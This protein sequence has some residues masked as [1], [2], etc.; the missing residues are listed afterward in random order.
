ME[1]NGALAAS[2]KL[3]SG[4]QFHY[5]LPKRK[6]FFLGVETKHTARAVGARQRESIKKYIF[7]KKLEN[8]RGLVL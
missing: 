5:P 2:A 4:T 8:W 1:S 7:Y 3:L 6:L